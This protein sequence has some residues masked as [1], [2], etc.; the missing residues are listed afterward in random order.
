MRP[1][2]GEGEAMN[3]LSEQVEASIARMQPDE[4]DSAASGGQSGSADEAEP[5]EYDEW[6]QRR[7]RGG[8][9]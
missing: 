6:Q 9:S 4:E 3:F 7:R 8:T 5:D 1:L 2:L